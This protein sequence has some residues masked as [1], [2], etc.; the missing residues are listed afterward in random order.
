[1]V[2][3]RR[4]FSCHEI[5]VTISNSK[6]LMYPGLAYDLFWIPPAARLHYASRL[7][8]G[9]GGGGVGNQT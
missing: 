8:E 1:M 4:P 6:F 7:V 5:A 9:V 3:P 2:N